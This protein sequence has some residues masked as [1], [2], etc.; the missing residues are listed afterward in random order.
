M[1]PDIRRE[2][3]LATEREGCS[4]TLR[5]LSV[6]AVSLALLAPTSCAQSEGKRAAGD[7]FQKYWSDFRAAAVSKDVDKVAAL[8]RFPFKTKGILDSDPQ[9]T[10]DAAG[11]RKLFPK[12]LEQDTGLRPEP[13]PM[14]RYIE[15]TTAPAA[16]GDSARVG[17]FVFEKAQGKWQFAL[18]Y[19]E[20]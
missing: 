13:E 5:I 3:T 15:R 9:K 18:A 20:E 14:L 16:K 7:D 4:V 8:T 12:L 19:V 1:L 11:F 17:Q 2:L 10:Y 6:A